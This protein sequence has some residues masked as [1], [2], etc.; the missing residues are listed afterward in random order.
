MWKL[1]CESSN[2]KQKRVIYSIFYER[3][4]TMRNRVQNETERNQLQ[5]YEKNED[6]ENLNETIWIMDVR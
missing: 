2:V 3:K 6:K 5:S 4:N 1:H